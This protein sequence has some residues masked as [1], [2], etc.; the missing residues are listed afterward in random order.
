MLPSRSPE[1]Q[2]DSAALT[3]QHDLLRRLNRGEDLSQIVKSAR[4]E[5]ARESVLP[6]LVF[7]N[8]ATRA[9]YWPRL[10]E[11]GMVELFIDLATAPQTRLETDVSI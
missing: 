11:L 4:K 6:Y 10:R 2:Y 1:D 7:I 5:C 8:A 9:C 3:E